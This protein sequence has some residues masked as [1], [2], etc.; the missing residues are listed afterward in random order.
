MYQPFGLRL[1]VFGADIDMILEA[2]V[3]EC[4][5]RFVEPVEDTMMAAL[6]ATFEI[7]PPPP[8]E[9]AKRGRGRE[10]DEARA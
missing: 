9:H 6:F 10:E 5:A 1:R 3:P 2:R 7:P 8:Q 4:E